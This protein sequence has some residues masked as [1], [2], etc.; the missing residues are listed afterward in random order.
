VKVAAALNMQKSVLIADI[1]NQRFR[2]WVGGCRTLVMEFGPV[3]PF[4]IMVR[5]YRT[6]V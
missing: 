1:D 2:V 3:F 6:Y 4:D 5:L